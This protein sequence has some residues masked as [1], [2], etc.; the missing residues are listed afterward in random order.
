MQPGR[1]TEPK[2]YQ[3]LP[4]TIAAMPK[5]FV[6]GWVIPPH[7]HARDQLLFAQQGIMR[8]R[9]DHCTWVVPRNSAVYIPGGT[10]HS[11][12]M[13]GDVDMRTLYIDRQRVRTAP[14]VLTVIA[15]STL[16]RELILALCEEPVDYAPESRAAR[17]ASLIE[18]EIGRAKS[19]SFNV[20]LPTDPRLQKVCAQLL[21]FPSDRRS[22]DEWSDLAGV[23]PRTLARLFERDLGMGMNRWRQ[24]IRFQGALESLFDGMPISRVARMHGY[25]SPSAFTSAF[26][27]TMGFTPSSVLP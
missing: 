8:L 15:V 18:A 5:A 23:S 9:T 19:L 1:S 13:H 21:A 27:K 22:L 25:N 6:D 14:P 20:P 11:V 4:Q 3:D 7:H 26:R 12:I 17:V 2:D 16:L 24:R 10:D